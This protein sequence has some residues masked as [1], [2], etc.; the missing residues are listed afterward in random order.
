MATTK[1]GD[2]EAHKDS[3]MAAASAGERDAHRDNTAGKGGNAQSRDSRQQQQQLE[4]GEEPRGQSE[5]S[6]GPAAAAGDALK[7]TNSRFGPGNQGQG[8]NSN[9]GPSDNR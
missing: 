9:S 1:A 8:N 5:P 3:A 7:R 4:P 6:A 2:R